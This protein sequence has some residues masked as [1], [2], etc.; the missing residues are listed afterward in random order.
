MW[1]RINSY[2]RISTTFVADAAIGACLVLTNDKLTVSSKECSQEN[3]RSSM[4]TVSFTTAEEGSRYDATVTGN[5]VQLITDALHHESE[6][7][8]HSFLLEDFL[9]E[10]GLDVSDVTTEV[11]S[12]FRWPTFI[13]TSIARPKTIIPIASLE[14]LHA[15]TPPQNPEK[16]REMCDSIDSTGKCSAFFLHTIDFAVC[17]SSV[18][19]PLIVPYCD[20]DLNRYL[21]IFYI[22]E[23]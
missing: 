20:V 3:L 8:S 10:V 2:T 22:H 9:F 23:T 15:A 6:C 21:F 19:C 17:L 4:T 7:N 13:N 16:F 5:V 12:G 18:T 14:R 11:D 1:L